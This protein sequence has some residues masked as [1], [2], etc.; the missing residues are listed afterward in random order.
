MKKAIGIIL[1]ILSFLMSGYSIL[2]LAA[3]EFE[4]SNIYNKTEELRG[5]GI[6]LLVVSVILFTIGLFMTASKSSKQRAIE[7]ELSNLKYAKENQ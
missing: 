6:G 1:T 3:S 4:E 7:M 2:L 5:I